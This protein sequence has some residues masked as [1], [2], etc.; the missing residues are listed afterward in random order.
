[1]LGEVLALVLVLAVHI[2]GAIPIHDRQGH[3]DAVLF[4][5]GTYVASRCAIDGF[6]TDGQDVCYFFA[7]GDDLL[8]VHF[9]IGQ[10]L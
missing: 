8:D 9:H 6:L 3:M 10:K 4:Q 2:L 1:M 7:L 5:D